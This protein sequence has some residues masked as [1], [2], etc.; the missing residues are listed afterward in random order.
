MQQNN[1]SSERSGNTSLL[2]SLLLL[3]VFVLSAVFLILIGSQVYA[4][5]RERN[6]NSFYSDTAS[7]YIVNKIRQ[8]D[9]KDSIELRTEEGKQILVIKT[10]QGTET[11]ETWIYTK[12]GSLMELFTPTDSGL[13]IQDGLEILPCYDV[14]FT[15]DSKTNLLGI[16]ITDTKGESSHTTNLLLRSNN[17]RRSSY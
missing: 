10:N 12:D 17:V 14:S 16:T 2:F 3:L 6:S 5:I 13:T 7:N 15:L 9:A 11:F 8:M 4:N 1:T